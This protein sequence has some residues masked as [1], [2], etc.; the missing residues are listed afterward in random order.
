MVRANESIGQCWFS[1]GS[2][3]FFNCRILESSIRPVEGGAYFISSERR[4]SHTP[5][6]YTIRFIS[7]EGELERIGEFQQYE[8]A[9]QA[10]GALKALLSEPKY[11]WIVYLREPMGGFEVAPAESIEHAK[12]QLKGYSMNTFTYEQASATLYPYSEED[13]AEAKEYE[14]IGC[15]FDCPSKVMSFGP[16]GGIKMENA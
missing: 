10:K 4:E 9:N 8:T 2:M 15:P 12:I 5:R 3:R 16:R 11:R 1:K 14:E 6:L 7:D 13:W